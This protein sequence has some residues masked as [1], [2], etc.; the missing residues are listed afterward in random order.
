MYK[1]ICEMAHVYMATN[2]ESANELVAHPAT[3]DHIVHLLYTEAATEPISFISMTGP[4]MV[5]VKTHLGRL[6]IVR[7]DTIPPGTFFLDR[8]GQ[9]K[10]H[11]R[12]QWVA[13]P[14]LIGA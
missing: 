6:K 9:S 4:D 8:D 5:V 1:T 13:A 12:S 3:I 2:G 11:P 14:K 10:K 7:D